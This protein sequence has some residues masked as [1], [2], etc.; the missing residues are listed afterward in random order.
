MWVSDTQVVGISWTIYHFR[1]CEDGALCILRLGLFAS[2]AYFLAHNINTMSSSTFYI[3]GGL[4][5]RASKTCC[6]I[7]AL[8]PGWQASGLLSL[9][10][11]LRVGNN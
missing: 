10:E 2:S 11:S 7:L 4:T 8:R 9:L 5:E 6:A 1:Y 3:F